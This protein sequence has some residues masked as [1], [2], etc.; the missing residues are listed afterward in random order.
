MG[1]V[2]VPLGQTLSAVL[3]NHPVVGINVVIILA[4]IL[5]IG[6]RHEDGVQIQN[7]HAQ[8]LQIVQF[9]PDSLDISAVKSRT[10]MG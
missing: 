9:V 1:I 5:M 3:H 6:G 10:S 2:I 7:L 8:I 4:V